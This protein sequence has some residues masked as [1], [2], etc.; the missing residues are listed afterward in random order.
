MKKFLVLMVL[1]LT[2][3]LFMAQPSYALV[4]EDETHNLTFTYTVENSDT[5][6]TYTWIEVSLDFTETGYTDIVIYFQAP[7]CSSWC[8]ELISME[9]QNGSGLNRES[10]DINV[11]FKESGFNE[12]AYSIDHYNLDSTTTRLYFNTADITTDFEV[13][14]GYLEEYILDYMSI[15]EGDLNAFYLEYYTPNIDDA[16]ADGYDAGE[17]VGYAD[18]YDVGYD[19]GYDIGYADA[20][21]LSGGDYLDG[22]T[23]GRTIG[24]NDVWLHGSGAYSYDET[25]SFDYVLGQL[26]FF[27][28]GADF[29][30]YEQ[31]DG[32]DY[33]E[34]YDQGV[35][36]SF[37]SS[38]EDSIIQFN[39]GFDT[40][41]VPAIIIV[42]LLGGFIT[43]YAK[44]NKG[45]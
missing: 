11:Y 7:S 22:F 21:E 34:G 39:N 15:Y 35:N 14:T 9:Y 29:N 19:A 4:L 3:F 31:S 40:W 41:I 26:Y 27:Q 16:Y 38:V 43:I 44:K 23:D 36:D 1:L 25:I 17:V 8:A 24:R 32:F 12:L 42:I 13:Q 6:T 2:M 10:A 30:G 28:Y 33:S 18:G 45:D 37:G 20:I 5:E